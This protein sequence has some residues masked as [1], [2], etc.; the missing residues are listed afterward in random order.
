MFPQSRLCLCDDG[1]CGGDGE[2]LERKKS[3]KQINTCES[4]L[5][6]QISKKRNN[7]LSSSPSLSARQPDRAVKLIYQSSPIRSYPKN[8]LF[9]PTSLSCSPCSLPPSFHP[10]L[11]PHPSPLSLSSQ[12][13]HP[14]RKCRQ[15]KTKKKIKR[16]EKHTKEAPIHPSSHPAFFCTTHLARIRNPTENPA[17]IGRRIQIVATTGLDAQPIRTIFCS[18]FL[19]VS[20]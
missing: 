20:L 8:P 18:F 6:F 16:K 3:T 17:I 4:F 9:H 11:T 12:F 14:K 1:D 19:F 10:P 2:E 7:P 15:K 5:S 13:P